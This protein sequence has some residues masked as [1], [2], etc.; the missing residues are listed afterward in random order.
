MSR[1]TVDLEWYDPAAIT[2]ANGSLQITFDNIPSHN[3]SFQSGHLSSWNKF[4]F[5]GGYVEVS[6][7]LPARPD[8]GGLWPA[9]WTMGNL[10]RAGYGASLD[11]MWPY[12]YDA[13]DVGTLPTQSQNHLPANAWINGDQYNAGQLSNL[14]GQRLSACTCA[15]E[16]HPGPTKP[17]GTFVGRSAPEIDVLEA[18]VRTGR[19]LTLSQT[20]QT[21]FSRSTT[22]EAMFPKVSNL[23]HSTTNTPG[24]THRKIC[25][26]KT[27]PSQ[28][29]TLTPG[30]SFNK[31]FQD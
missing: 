9:V 6:V 30:V 24:T 17:D 18:V 28:L 27:R 3:M 7:S 1:Q 20:H 10:G 19:T 31:L 25:R 26:F 15:G 13:C 21:S 4:C 2:T 22:G 8:Q 23:R 14:T 12:S 29:S 11:G 16:D 5:T